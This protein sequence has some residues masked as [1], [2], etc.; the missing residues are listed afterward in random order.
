MMLPSPMK[1]INSFFECMGKYIDGN[2]AN[3]RFMAH[4]AHMHYIW[5]LVHRR[6]QC[7]Y[8]NSGELIL[9]LKTLLH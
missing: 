2:T 3:V 4:D 6:M 1:C 8:K 5:N 7:H 9:A